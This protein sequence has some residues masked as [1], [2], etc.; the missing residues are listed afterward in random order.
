MEKIYP[1][2]WYPQK[3]GLLDEKRKAALNELKNDIMRY[4]GIKNRTTKYFDTFIYKNHIIM[5][6]GVSGKNV[7]L[8]LDLDTTM[9]AGNQFPNKNMAYQKRHRNT[10]FLMKIYSE[11]SL[12]RGHTLIHDLAVI[13]KLKEK[14]EYEDKDYISE[15][16]ELD[17]SGILYL[18]P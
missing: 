7:K 3:V 16:K 5:K 8:F 2:K 1:R 14:E 17:E 4:A 15:I 9:Y 12:K 6:L 10:P 13:K 18:K 11:L